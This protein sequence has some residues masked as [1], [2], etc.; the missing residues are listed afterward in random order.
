[1]I[2]A[3]VDDPAMARVVGIRVSRLFTIVFCLGAWLAGFAGVIGGPILSVY[4]GLDQEM[5][6]LALVVVIL[7]GS[8]SLLGSLVGQLRRRLPLQL[9]PGDVPRARLRRAVP[10]DA[11]RAR[12]AAPGSVRAAGGVK[13]LA[14][15]RRARGPRRRCRSGS[16]APTTSTSPARSCST[17]SSRSASTCWSA[18]RGSSRSATPGSSASPPTPGRG[19]CNGGHGHVGRRR[20]RA[21]GDARGRG[22]LRGARAARHRARLRHD[23]GGAGPDR[24]GRRLSLDQHHQRRQRHH[25]HRAAE[26]VRPVARLGGR[27]LL[28]DARRVPRSPSRSMA[29]FVASPFGASLRGTRDQPRRMN[30][31]GYH[32]WM[33]RFLAF[34]FSGVLERRGRAA[35]P[36][37]QPVREPAGGG[38][39]RLRRGAPDGDLRRHGHP[40]RTDR[41]RRRSSSS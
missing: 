3:G 1:M 5:L 4:P 25:D 41:R 29:I 18:T 6:P 38:P 15:R 27:L 23:H 30:A 35:L 36:L 26:P 28:G 13:R 9:R 24:L 7:G 16:A 31:L 8:G 17:R 22:A 14:A 21:R 12:G 19:S 37:L 39:H 20:G 2:R 40:A 32:V 10:A 11:D 34:L 33:I